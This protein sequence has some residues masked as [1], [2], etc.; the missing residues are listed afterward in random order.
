MRGKNL[1]GQMY[2]TIH[3][4]TNKMFYARVYIY[5]LYTAKY[6]IHL[7][8]LYLMCVLALSSSRYVKTKKLNT[9]TVIT[10]TN[11]L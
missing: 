9:R 1:Y 11:N 5:S 6:L 3:R 4:I 8:T 2:K 10:D 7:R